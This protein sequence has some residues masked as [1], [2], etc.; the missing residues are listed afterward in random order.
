MESRDNF[1]GEVPDVEEFVTF[2]A[3]I[4]EQEPKTPQQ[5]WMDEIMQEL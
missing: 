5:P 2:W 1:S 4:W 3:D